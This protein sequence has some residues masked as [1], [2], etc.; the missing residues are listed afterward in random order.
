MVDLAL[1]APVLCTLVR[2]RGVMG[3]YWSCL[4]PYSV[5]LQND[6]QCKGRGEAKYYMMDVKRDHLMMYNC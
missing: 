1:S 4:R 3:F 2:V 5:G 6:Q